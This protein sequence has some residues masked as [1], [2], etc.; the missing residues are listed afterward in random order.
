MKKFVV[1]SGGFHPFHAGHASLYQQAK[2]AFPDA[3]VLVCATNVQT[4]RPFPFKIKKKLAQ[5]SGVPPK[6]FIEVS[7]Q[8]TIQDPALARRIGDPNNAIVIYVR[9]D[10]DKNEP[11]LPYKPN[12]DG[13]PVLG[14]RGKPLSDYLLEYP[15]NNAKLSPA[16]E[17]AYMAYLKTVEF[18]PGITSASEIRAKWPTLNDRRKLAMVMSLY[19]VTQKDPKVAKKVVE[20]FD[21]V[22]GGQEGVAEGMVIGCC[23]NEDINEGKIKDIED[24]LARHAQYYL[25]KEQNDGP[26]SGQDI[27][28]RETIRKQLLAKKKRLQAEK[29]RT[30]EDERTE[31]HPDSELNRLY[32][33]AQQH[34][35]NMRNKQ[36]AFVKYVT[37]ALKH[38]EDD[39]ARQDNQIDILDKEV[40][41]IQKK[42]NVTENTDYLEEK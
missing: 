42:L 18:G 2:E 38:S 3:T 35:P 1:M 40:D 9:S 30:N 7:K 25:D 16:T 37:H 24:L 11:P 22:M 4:D 33:F 12:P 17:H 19:P 14:K 29:D 28:S 6:D 26:L 41:Q 15:G 8:F 20:I 13:S 23:P 34:Y 10:K 39:D 5:L 32:Q 36:D 31:I 21:Q 27:H